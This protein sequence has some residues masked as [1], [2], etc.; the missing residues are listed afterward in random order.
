MTNQEKLNQA[1]VNV[2]KALFGAIE[3]EL[4][5][6][7]F[8]HNDMLTVSAG[9]FGNLIAGHVEMIGG[10]KNAP[11]LLKCKVEWTKHLVQACRDIEEYEAP[12]N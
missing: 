12:I 4:S 7:E 6:K 10:M 3:K 9:V 2:T 5:G 11:E 1:T 8:D